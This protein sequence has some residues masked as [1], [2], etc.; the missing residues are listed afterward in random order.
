MH[1]APGIHRNEWL[2][3]KLDDGTSTDW[4]RGIEIF[5]ERINSR[6]IEPVDLLIK[7]DH[8]QSASKRRYGFSIL[9]VD[10]LLIETLQSFREG[11]IDTKGKSQKMFEKFLTSR[12]GFCEHFDK[13]KAAN[14]YRDIRCGILHQAEVMG[15][16]LIWSVGKLMRVKEDGT[17]YIN[18]TKFHEQLKNEVKRYCDE[19]RDQANS[20]LRKNFRTKMDAIARKK[21]LA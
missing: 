18:R 7:K 6:Y 19:L 8:E 12:N 16:Y 1:I 15:S 20:N 11:L 21:D 10:C 17:C 14:F 9:A 2:K 3:L 5:N 4:K 13:E